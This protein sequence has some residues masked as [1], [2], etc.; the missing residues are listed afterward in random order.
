MAGLFVRGDREVRRIYRESYTLWGT[1]LTPEGYFGL[2]QDLRSTTW[3][4][5]YLDFM[6]WE[7]GGAILSSLKRYRPL[8]CHNGRTERATVIGAVYTPARYRRE[9]FAAALIRAVLDQGLQSGHRSTLLFSD[10]GTAYYRDLGFLALPANA[11]MAG[12]IPARPPIGGRVELSPLD[13]GFL[14]ELLEAHKAGMRC[15]GTHIV[16]DREHWEFLLAR[17]D[18]YFSRAAAIGRQRF[19]VAHRAGTFLGYLVD[20]EADGQW[21][22]REVG[23]ADGLPSTMADILRAAASAKPRRTVRAAYGWL[24]QALIDCL[25]DWDWT[26]VPRDRAIPMIHTAVATEDS[27]RTQGRLNSFFP[28]MDQF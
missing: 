4:S 9:G 25:P 15:Y 8:L 7:E 17:A 18:R 28:Y 20:I 10:I 19:L 27:D 11:V 12:L 23:S 16:R 26:V 13:A 6:T 3:G 22:I 24:P 1:G 14:P 2:W 5:R 21:E